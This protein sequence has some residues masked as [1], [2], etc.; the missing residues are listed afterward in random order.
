MPLGL[1]ETIHQEFSRNKFC[2]KKVSLA[3]D[4]DEIPDRDDTMIVAF[5]TLIRLPVM[6]PELPNHGNC[7][8][9][10]LYVCGCRWYL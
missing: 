4:S 6:R 10:Y 3:E 1:E 7:M 8:Y 2:Q 9:Q 5:E